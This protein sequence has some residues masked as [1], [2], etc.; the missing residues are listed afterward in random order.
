[1]VN[2]VTG[3]E[4][5]YVQ[6]IAENGLPSAE[7]FPITLAQIAA[8]ATAES[9]AVKDTP[10]TT[11]GNG[12]L[13]A[14]GLVGGQIT[15]SG[16]TSAFTDTTATAAQIVAA[17]PQFLSGS[18]FLI[19]IKNATAFLE[20]IAA[21]TNVTL[22]L[23]VII[24]PYSVGNYFAM[25]GGTAA[26]PTVTISHMSTVTLADS[27]TLSAPSSTALSTV[28]AATI[29][30]AGISGGFTTRSG[31]QTAAFTD[32]T[33]TAANIIAAQPGLVNKIGSAFLYTY[34]NNTIWPATIAGGTGVTVSSIIKAPANS[35][36]RYLLTYT[37]ANTITM[38]GN[39]LSYFTSTGTFTANGTTPVTVA[40]AAVTAGSIISFT[41][42]TVGGTVSAT[43][44]NVQTITPGTGF[45]VAGLAADTSVYNYIIQG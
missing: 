32:T 35:S 1:M 31:T 10:I 45:T 30:A 41:L 27:I 20:T 37:A 11:V 33:D 43:Q 18:V 16:P 38:V 29:T 39:D 17:L 36:V 3:A 6:G 5:L 9:V 25:I 4:I 19:R 8:L 26:S 44:P 21:G 2:P 14:A 24:A 13:T 22:P 42:K 15:R 28:G 23:T 7:Q 12:T 40:N 34:I